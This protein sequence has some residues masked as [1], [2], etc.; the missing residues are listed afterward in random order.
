MFKSTWKPF[1]LIN[2]IPLIFQR[3]ELKKNPKK[4]LKK[5]LV[6]YCRSMIFI[7]GYG[8]FMKLAFCKIPK[9]TGKLSSL[10]PL[11]YNILGCSSILF[12][13]KRRFSFLS[14]YIFYRWIQS[15]DLFFGKR[16]YS[17]LNEKTLVNLFFYSDIGLCFGLW[18]Y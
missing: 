18:N 8:F 9:T 17:V 6:G 2:L 3:K 5:F 11:M 15:M 12:E 16:G 13:E 7:F 14:M 10:E 4:V 1:L